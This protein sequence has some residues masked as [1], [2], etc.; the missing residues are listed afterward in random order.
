[1]ALA[2]L[3]APAAAPEAVTVGSASWTRWQDPAPAANST[4]AGSHGA[5][6][7]ASNR[8][9]LRRR[10]RRSLRRPGAAGASR[11]G[12]FTAYELALNAAKSARAKR[13]AFAVEER[14]Q[15]VASDGRRPR[16]TPR[17]IAP[18]L[19]G[20]T[21]RE[22]PQRL[23]PAEGQVDRLHGLPGR[24][25]AGD[26]PDGI[27][28]DGITTPANPGLP[29]ATPP[30]ATASIFRDRRASST[31][32][33]ATSR[34]CIGGAQQPPAV[35]RLHPHAVDVVDLRRRLPAGAPDLLDD[36]EL[37]HL[38]RR[39]L[40]SSGVLTTR[41]QRAAHLRQAL[42]RHGPP[43]RA[44]G[45]RRRGRRRSRNSGR[46]RRC[47]RSNSPASGAPVST[48]FDLM[49]E[50]PV[51]HISGLPPGARDLVEQHLAST[52]RRR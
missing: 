23:P 37:A 32:H 15:V 25:R 36:R 39:R 27:G 30:P 9:P 24:R 48:I 44:G 11:V 50:W 3:G 34:S 20:L 12:A 14:S 45:R 6:S 41:G 1:M 47:A 13:V 42:R 31:L 4:Q 46:R 29:P 16:A 51:C 5:G 18:R 10:P 35:G 17:S 38:R 8:R 40:R 19:V 43:A 21:K 33:R 28:A 26:D 49:S 7:P 52:S 22:R 2:A